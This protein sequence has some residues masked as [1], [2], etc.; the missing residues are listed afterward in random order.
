MAFGSEPSVEAVRAFLAA[1]DGGA[2]AHPTLKKP[3]EP[4]RVAP[5]SASGCRSAPPVASESTGPAQNQTR[6]GSDELENSGQPATRGT[7]GLP[8]AQQEA[9]AHPNSP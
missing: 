6:P 8:A 5:T 1:T 7:Q 2:R 3:E 4:Y 9:L